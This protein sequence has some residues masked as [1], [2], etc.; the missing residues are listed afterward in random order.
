[1]LAEEEKLLDDVDGVNYDVEGT[2]VTVPS[3]LMCLDYARRLEQ[4]LATKIDKLNNLRGR[5]RTQL[6]DRS[7]PIANLKGFRQQLQ[8]EEQTSKNVKKLRH[9]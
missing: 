5:V 9:V 8:R 7:N 6:S 3:L 1:M 4:I 2:R